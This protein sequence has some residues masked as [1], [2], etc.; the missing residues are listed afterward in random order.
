MR[1]L[2]LF[3]NLLNGNDLA[4]EKRSK[5]KRLAVHGPAGRIT[6]KSPPMG[7]ASRDELAIAD[8]L[9]KSKLGGKR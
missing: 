2:T 5:R 9:P 6:R 7:R 1:R 4:V 3:L 8:A